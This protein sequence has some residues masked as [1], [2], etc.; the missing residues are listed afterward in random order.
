[1]HKKLELLVLFQ[2]IFLKLL[3]WIAMFVNIKLL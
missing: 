3:Y 2:D 1:M